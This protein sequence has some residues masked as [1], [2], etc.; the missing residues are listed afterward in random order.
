MA[1][2]GPQRLRRP[3]QFACK[4]WVTLLIAADYTAVGLAMYQL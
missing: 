3:N 4:I 1:R 2:V